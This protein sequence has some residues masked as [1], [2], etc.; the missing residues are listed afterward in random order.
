MTGMSREPFAGALE[1]IEAILASEPEPD[2]V[3]R[4]TIAALAERLPRYTWAGLFL[5]EDGALA[6]GPSTAPSEGAYVD[7][8][9]ASAASNDRERSAT[10]IAVPVRFAEHVVGVI[11][12]RSGEPDSIRRDDEI[13]LDRVAALI[14]PHCLVGWDTGGATWGE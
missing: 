3:L 7:L 5:L 4:Q 10:G 11:V 13:F 9:R 14:S 2:V 8:A 12:V 1:A 6:L